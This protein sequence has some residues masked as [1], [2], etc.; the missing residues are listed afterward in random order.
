MPL[1]AHLFRVPRYETARDEQSGER[2]VQ[3]DV[4]SDVIPVYSGWHA[5][6]AKH[7]KGET[8]RTLGSRW[9]ALT[10]EEKRA[11]DDMA[12]HAAQDPR[13]PAAAVPPVSPVSLADFLP[14]GVGDEDYPLDSTDASYV[15]EHLDELV[16]RFGAA[17]GSVVKPDV[18]FK[19]D[20]VHQCCDLFDVGECWHNMSE[21]EREQHAAVRKKMLAFAKLEAHKPN[22]IA[23]HVL[24]KLSPADADRPSKFVLLLASLLNPWKQMFL[25]CRCDDADAN[26]GI[27]SEIH[28]G[29]DRLDLGA[30][31]GHKTLAMWIVR[32]G[33]ISYTRLF[34]EYTSCSTMRVLAAV[35]A[36]P[37]CSI[38]RSRVVEKDLLEIEKLLKKIRKDHA[39]GLRRRW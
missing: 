24:L 1:A 28:L 34:Y 23:L 37:K 9:T 12:T 10:P 16:N 6:V 38:A 7:V 19:D 36:L 14:C 20:T 33:V 3:D 32:G 18:P 26:V 13:L 2:Q 27:G 22:G 35:D 5:F 17:M 8:L 25:E 29:L 15:I 4:A 39:Q 21:L 30:V 31:L 11:Y